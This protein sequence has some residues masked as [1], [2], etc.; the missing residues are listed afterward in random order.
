MAIKQLLVG[1][2]GNQ[3]STSAARQAVLMAQKYDASITGI[4]VFRHEAFESHIRRWIPDDV[5]A[6]MQ[7]VTIEAE[8]EFEKSFRRTLQEAGFKGD[9]NWITAEGS[10]IVVLP[11]YAR[12]F[13]MLLLGQFTQVSRAERQ[14]LSPEDL[15]LRAGVPIIIVP[16]N[17]DVRPLKERAA[18]AWDGS[19]SAARALSDAMLILETK[20]NLDVLR[21]SDDGKVSDKIPPELDIVARMAAHGV[22]ARTI[23]L[24]A[25]ADGIGGAIVR[26]CAEHDPDV[27]VMGAYGRG[28]FMDLLFGGATRYVL[29]NMTVPVL[30]SH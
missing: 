26:Y 16:A 14:A 21:V 8:R 28:K 27:L 11:R 6:Q 20:D 4:H 23:D 9:V 5:V 18:V 22:N 24:T 1:F 25:G 12:Y 13:D 2:D 30:M 17:Y 29:V 15:L 10:A 3:A 19:R 7:G